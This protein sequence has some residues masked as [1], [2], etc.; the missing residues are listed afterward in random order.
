MKQGRSDAGMYFEQI[1]IADINKKTARLQRFNQGLNVI[2]SEENHVGK[3]S[4]LK[5]LYYTLGA[6]V[7]YDNVWDKNTKVCLN[8]RDSG[9]E[10][11]RKIALHYIGRKDLMLICSHKLQWLRP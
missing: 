10:Q 1:I 8:C 4:L 9:R 7:I 6:E 2:T 3:S 5:S 11:Q